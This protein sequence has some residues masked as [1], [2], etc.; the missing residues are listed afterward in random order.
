MLTRYFALAVGIIYLL[1]GLLGFIPGLLSDRDAPADLAVDTL[2]GR[3]IG[4]FPV[5]VLH[6]IVHLAIG[7]LGILAYRSFDASR[8]FARGLAIFYGLLAVM[9]LIE[10]ANINL[11]FGLIPLHS[12][13]IWLHAVTA[14]VAA[15]FGWGAPPATEAA[16]GAAD[17]Y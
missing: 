8:T 4:L 11:T 12:H 17:R 5:N 9:G 2:Y 3:L 7:V 14:A 1:V 6:S 10:P 13:D 16:P 15:Y